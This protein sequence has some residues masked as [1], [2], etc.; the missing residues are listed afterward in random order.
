MP[1]NPYALARALLCTANLLVLFPCWLYD[2]GVWELGV[3]CVALSVES[4]LRAIEPPP[5]PRGQLRALP[6]RLTRRP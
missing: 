4:L 3:G 1:L 2:R 6:G 5:A